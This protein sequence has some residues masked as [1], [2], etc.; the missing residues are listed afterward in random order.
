MKLPTTM[1][2]DQ[3]AA[4]VGGRVHGKGD[5]KVT[6][7]CM[8]PLEGKEDQIAF[9]FEASMVKAL[10]ESKV[11]AAIVPTG[12]EKDYPDRN[13][14]LVDR[15]KVAL[16]RV[17]KTLEPKRCV[18]ENKV[19]ES[20]VIDPSVQLGKNVSIGPLVVIG[21]NSKIGDNTKIMP[22]TVIGGDVQIG[23]DCLIHAGCL[24]ADYVKVGNR[25]ILQQGVSLGGDG[26]GYTTERPSNME[27]R[28]ARVDGFSDEDNPLVKIPQ[29]G[30]VVL[31]DDVEVGSNTTIDRGTIGAT[32]IG[33]GC[34]IDNLVMIGH[35][36]KL[37]KECI[38][39]AN[40]TI[41]GSAVI[42]DRVVMAGG[43]CVKDQLKVGKDAIL[44]GMAGVMKEVPEGEVQVGIPAVP[45]R[46]FY[47][48]VVGVR[49]LPDLMVDFRKLQK[50]VTQLEQQLLEKQLS[51]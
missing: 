10:G 44:E 40:T 16:A 36:V 28:L 27:L 34:K 24:I 15:P 51:N 8:Q 32:V 19:H 21:Q 45:Y 6:S 46:K 18:Q 43:V 48:Q 11:G 20:A 29:I 13:L 41:G 25:V 17:L 26:F 47:E 50:R 22:G 49:K 35:N 3:V 37:G 42:G 30:T 1:T 14:I 23:N 7:L 38:V 31:E 33:K 4:F 12:V 2:L 5:V 39:V 9:F